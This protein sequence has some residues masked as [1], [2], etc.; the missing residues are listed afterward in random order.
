MLA[1]QFV[2]AVTRRAIGKPVAA[3]RE[4]VQGEEIVLNGQSWLVQRVQG[5]R[6]LYGEDASGKVFTTHIRSVEVVPGRL[7]PRLE[8]AGLPIPIEG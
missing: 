6:T 3:P 5:S 1:F 4:V 7:P 2:D 8:F